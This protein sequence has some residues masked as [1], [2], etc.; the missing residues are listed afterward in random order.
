MVRGHTEEPISALVKDVGQEPSGSW[1]TCQSLLL[2]LGALSPGYH[3]IMEVCARRYQVLREG[4]KDRVQ[5]A[6]Y[7]HTGG[8]DMRRCRAP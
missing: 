2:C 8:S 4:T 1:A 7:A 3:A 6:V 5:L